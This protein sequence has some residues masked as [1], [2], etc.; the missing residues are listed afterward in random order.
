MQEFKRQRENH[1]L[2]SEG[3]RSPLQL[4]TAGML[5]NEH[6]G[7]AAVASVFDPGSMHDY[8]FDP[9]GPFPIEE[10]Y[11]VVVPDTTLPISDQQMA[12]LENQC[13]PLQENDR[14]GENTYL[15]CLRILSSFI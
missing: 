10:D 14:S 5:E 8:G 13:N 9:S 15:E 11:Q 6:S 1:P 2:S 7:Y 4:Y 3:N 12:F